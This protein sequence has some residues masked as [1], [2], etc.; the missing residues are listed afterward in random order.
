MAGGHTNSADAGNTGHA[1]K[2]MI[3]NV[4]TDL[5]EILPSLR[6]LIRNPSSV[7]KN[8]HQTAAIGI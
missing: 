8:G 6:G 5:G 4:T 7:E 2:A 1:V 3:V